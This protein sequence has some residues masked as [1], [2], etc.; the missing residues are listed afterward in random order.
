MSKVGIN[1][2]LP[3]GKVVLGIEKTVCAS[4]LKTLKNLISVKCYPS[5]NMP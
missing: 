4:T 2:F 1:N 3:S 5:P